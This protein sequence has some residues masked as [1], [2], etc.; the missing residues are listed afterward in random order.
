MMSKAVSFLVYSLLAVFLIFYSVDRQTIGYIAF[1]VAL[2]LFGFML[3]AGF[4]A[5]AHSN[6]LLRIREGK[7]PTKSKTH[8]ST[9]TGAFSS[10]ARH[11]RMDKR[12]TGAKIIDQPLQEIIDL[13]F[14]DCIEWWYYSLIGRSPVFL[15]ELRQVSQRI[16]IAFSNRS[17]AVDWVPFITHRIVEDFAAHLRIYRSAEAKCNGKQAAI[18]SAFFDIESEMENASSFRNICTS[19]EM[20]KEYLRDLSEIFLYLLL[21]P[22]DFHCKPVRLLTRE[23]LVS[24]ALL[25]LA[26]TVS[27]PDYI[28]QTIVWLCY[29]SAFTPDSFTDI[30]RHSG[31]KDEVEEVENRLNEEITRLQAKDKEIASQPAVKK[32]L[33]S[34][35][36]LTKVCS[37]RRKHLSSGKGSGSS[38]LHEVSFERILR[39]NSTFAL[40]QNWLSGDEVGMQCLQFWQNAEGLR[41]S[42]EELLRAVRKAQEEGSSPPDISSFRQSA[43]NI[44]EEYLFKPDAH[45]AGID[46]SIRSNL[47]RTVQRSQLSSTWFD[48]AQKRVEGKLE[49]LFFSIFKN[50]DDYKRCCEE[51]EMD[52]DEESDNDEGEDSTSESELSRS[53]EILSLSRE[54]VDGTTM[55]TFFGLE[56]SLRLEAEV[57]QAG[58]CHEDGKQYALYAVKV[59]SNTGKGDPDIW[60]VPRRYSDFHDLHLV[61]KDKF[62][63]LDLNFPGK[64]PFKSLNREFLEKRRSALNDFIH[65][66]LNPDFLAHHSGVLKT[67]E[68]FLNKGEYFKEKGELARKVDTIVGP[69]KRTVRAA[70]VKV[71]SGIEA[72]S[73]A[74]RT[75][76]PSVSRKTPVGS[77]D[78]TDDAKVASSLLGAEDTDD[79]IPLR[80]LLLLMDEVFDLKTKSQ[81]LKRRIV[82]LLKDIIRTTFGDRINRKIVK[83]VEWLTSAEQIAEYVREL[84]DS[85]WPDGL[86]RTD[87]PERSEAVKNRTRVAA[88]AKMIGSFP[89]EL[90]RF[91]GSDVTREGTVRVFNMFQ[92]PQ[93]NKRLI[94]V[95]FEDLLTTLFPDNKFKEIFERLHPAKQAKP[96]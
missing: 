7:R 50:A 56:E 83:K 62:G 73:K 89:D 65:E 60:M 76:S 71:E 33:N 54:E 49:L 77:E 72:L 44:C 55:G 38:H 74:I 13:T 26:E 80:I 67:M 34:L 66:I 92:H 47:L 52:F 82:A 95:L 59:T 70:S 31:T 69:L 85:N 10:I 96:N 84:R 48:E 19:S 37:A 87:V 63:I 35:K 6:H 94:Y 5:T 21:P 28:N 90:K 25:P 32:E 8:F 39:N 61:L 20:E 40:F 91:I 17:K 18:E 53:I 45:I 3:V 43:Q 12:L 14:R 79:N 81:W 46:D 51:L 15:H 29:D 86:W 58:I 93:L 2:F 88:K 78:V 22:D 23:L 68:Y 11:L 24:R 42:A 27:D 30:V 64:R 9:L 4:H 16:I 57:V 1:H 41:I 36:F 75:D